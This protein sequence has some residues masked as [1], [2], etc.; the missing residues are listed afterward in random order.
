M[1]PPTQ[2]GGFTT[3]Q[4]VATDRPW[5]VDT[6]CLG[7]TRRGWSIREIVH[8]QLSVLRD[9]EG[10]LLGVDSYRGTGES[11]IDLELYPAWGSAASQEAPVLEAD[12]HEAMARLTAATEDTRAMRVQAVRNADSVLGTPGPAEPRER[13]LTSAMLRW[14][15]EDHFVFLGYREYLVNPDHEQ[16]TPVSGTG[17]GVLRDDRSEL[18]RGGN[19]TRAPLV[20]CVRR[21]TRRAARSGDVGAPYG[22]LGCHQ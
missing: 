5:I 2:A 11:W 14:L 15:L 18:C 17:L 21:W 6:L 16:F 3:V 10:R 7:A 12:L 13:A 9:D 8:P 1:H 22:D 20:D 19:R 4:V